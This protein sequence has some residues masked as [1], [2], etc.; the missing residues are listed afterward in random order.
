[1]S[2]GT[3]NKFKRHM[4]RT[5]LIVFISTG[6]I[7][8]ASVAKGNMLEFSTMRAAIESPAL[9]VVATMNHLINVLNNGS[10][11]MKFVKDMFV[12]IREN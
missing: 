6:R 12:V 2:V 1:M 8:T 9:R 4:H 5:H 3:G 10:S 7:E 11:R